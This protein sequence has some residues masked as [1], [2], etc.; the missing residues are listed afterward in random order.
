M[1]YRYI[2]FIDMKQYINEHK[3]WQKLAGIISEM[4]VAD[5]TYERDSYADLLDKTIQIDWENGAPQYIGKITLID[6]EEGTIDTRDSRG[7]GNRWGIGKNA[8][9]QLVSNGIWNSPGE[10][11][12]QIKVIDTIAEMKVTDPG[13]E[14]IIK[15]FILDHIPYTESDF[16]SYYNADSDSEDLVEAGEYVEHIFL[17]LGSTGDEDELLDLV[18]D[19]SKVEHRPWGDYYTNR[20]II[21]K[22]PF[23]DRPDLNWTEELVVRLQI[24]NGNYD[25]GNVFNND[26]GQVIEIR[27]SIPFDQEMV[28]WWTQHYG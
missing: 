4:K 13:I 19:S 20:W 23:E 28:A 7:G 5:P 21:K 22:Y 11:G 8:L 6:F 10:M 26:Y 18:K 17:E 25:V 15:N 1:G 2:I 12:V 9:N 16:D 3:R 14:N 24:P 27:R